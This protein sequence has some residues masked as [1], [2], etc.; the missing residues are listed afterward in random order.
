[1]I[2]RSHFN[3]KYALVCQFLEG[4]PSKLVKMTFITVWNLEWE[5]WSDLLKSNCYES[6]DFFFFPNSGAGTQI[7]ELHLLGWKYD[8]LPTWVVRL[9]SSPPGQNGR[10]FGRRHNSNA[11]FN[12]NDKIPVQISQKFIPRSPIGNKPSLVQVMAWRRTG[13]K[14]LSE[15]MLSQITDAY[16]RY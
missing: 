1:M 10:H 9:N 16:M 3:I 8:R 12:G 6:H 4:R 5:R 14:P 2:V 15:P 11:F 13:D 7:S